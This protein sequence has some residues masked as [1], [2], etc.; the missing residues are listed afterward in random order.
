MKT[1]L[2]ILAFRRRQRRRRLSVDTI[3]GQSSR[4][5]LSWRMFLSPHHPVYFITSRSSWSKHPFQ[6]L[7]K[8]VRAISFLSLALAMSNE[9]LKTISTRSNISFSLFPHMLSLTL[10][11]SFSQAHTCSLGGSPGL[12]VMGVDSRSNGRGFESRYRI[13]DGHFTL[14]CCKKII[15]CLKRPKINEKEAGVGP[16]Y[17]THTFSTTPPSLLHKTTS[18]SLSHTHT[19]AFINQHIVRLSLFFKKYGP[20]PDFFFIFD[21][22]IRTSDLKCRKWPFCQLSHNHY[23]IRLVLSLSLSLSLSLTNTHTQSLL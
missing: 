22:G 6:S 16:F 8:N 23:P 18:P 1:F 17:K 12:V 10:S 7:F 9:S 20:F 19:Y 2:A 5:S 4:R 14:I 21:D 11:F 13:L 15:V 3:E